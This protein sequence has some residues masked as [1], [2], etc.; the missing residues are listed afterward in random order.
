MDP[1]LLLAGSIPLLFNACLGRMHD[2][3]GSCKSYGTDFVKFRSLF[4]VECARFIKWGHTVGLAQPNMSASDLAPLAIS[5]INLQ[6][7][8]P[9]IQRAI[10]DLLGC[11][12]MVSQKLRL[13]QKNYEPR[14]GTHQTAGTSIAPKLN[15]RSI[16]AAADNLQDIVESISNQAYMSLRNSA[17]EH[18]LKT[19][20][21]QK[22]RWATIDK[23][24][25]QSLIIEFRGYNDGLFNLLPNTNTVMVPSIPDEVNIHNVSQPV[26]HLSIRNSPLLSNIASMA[27]V[28]Q[29]S[30]PDSESRIS[31]FRSE[32]TNSISLAPIDVEVVLGFN[33]GT[34]IVPTRNELF[35]NTEGMN[36]QRLTFL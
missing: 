10:L 16:M 12:Q 22:A 14:Q 18:Q 13:L 36:F 6:S 17:K 32:P 21:L 27:S 34:F 28:S 23:P 4:T 33:D 2:V 31:T 9:T 3:I 29:A 25:F 19:S 5:V 11:I 26:H 35:K 8:D 20:F 15:E 30:D 1:A 7:T 24:K